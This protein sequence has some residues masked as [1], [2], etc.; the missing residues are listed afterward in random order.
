MKRVLLFLPIIV[1]IIVT[2]CKDDENTNPPDDNQSD[3]L[4]SI[5]IL[6]TNDEHGWFEVTDYYDG[7]AG[8]AGLWE[9]EE[10]YDGSENFLILSGGDLWTGA[11]A[12]T[13]FEGES[14]VDVMNVMEYDAAA[15]G[16]H[17]FDFK[18][19]VLNQRLSEMDFPLL[20]ANIT[21]KSTGDIPDFAQP[22]IIKN[23]D[24]IQ[25][26][27]LGLASLSTPYSTFP[28]N[29]VDYNFTDYEDAI[30]T[31]AP[32]AISDGAEVLILIGHMCEDELKSIASVAK[33][34]GIS[35]M[36]GGHCNQIMAEMYNGVAL[37]G[38]YKYMKAY[39]KLEFN[40]NLTKELTQDFVFDYVS[41]D[42]G[43]TN[44]DV[45]TVVDYWMDQTNAV[46]SEV[47]G[48]AENDIPKSSIEMCNLV[49]DSW[50]YTF[51][52]ADI[53]ITN[54]GGI[55]QEIFAGD[56]TM[57]TMVGLLPFENTIYEL[58]LTGLEVKDC[59]NG[60]IFGG[61]TT[62]DGYF[63][64]DGTPIDDETIYTVLTTDYLYSQTSLNFA[65]YDDSPYLTAV[66]YRQPLVDWLKSINTT[67]GDPLENY[68]DY[69][70]RW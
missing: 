57:A 6:Y 43:A 66:H 59:V 34:N 54:S 49:C 17:E 42:Q 10:G 7:A 21:E 9:D 55:R 23:I 32:Q 40:Y 18:V 3:S 30:S 35:V 39:T 50:F 70:A 44:H 47:I 2:S 22:Y 52:D 56:I 69:T 51:P 45:K 19:S 13:W 26:G 37:L 11:A 4:I 20:A 67:S 25:I 8:L 27:I 65:T 68:L 14:M 64:A 12:S 33:S 46:L 41:N 29:V 16:N 5:T 38:A 58:E 1:L 31:Y 60:L 36:G 48:Y 15:I 62:V 28:A 63:L 53:A 24:G 61:M